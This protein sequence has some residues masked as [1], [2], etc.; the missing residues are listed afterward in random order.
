DAI[1]NDDFHHSATVALTGRAGAYYT[2][3]RGGPQEF[4]SAAKHGF[5]Y[6]G[7]HYRWHGRPRGTP[8]L[9]LPAH[10]FVAYLQN[11]DQI[12]NS[13]TA[14]RGHALSSPARWRAMTALLLLG[15]WTPLLFMG[16]EFAASSPFCYF[17]DHE[18]ELARLVQKGRL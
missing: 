2:D 5:L 8:T 3:Y 17:A 12:A 13:A 1:W 6:Q 11:H 10:A 18:P 4:V 9:G 15:P 7:Q 16:Q 14:A